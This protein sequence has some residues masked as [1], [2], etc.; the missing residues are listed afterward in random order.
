MCFT[1]KI[2]MTTAVIEFFVGTYLWLTLR[3]KFVVKLLVIFIYLL[4]LYQF[5]EFMLCTSDNPALWGRVGFVSYNFLPAVGL[6]FVIR[7]ARRKFINWVL[8]IPAVTFAVMALVYKDF[9]VASSCNTVFVT[10]KTL[11]FRDVGSIWFT[12][13]YWLYYFGFIFIG[14]W[15]LLLAFIKSKS[16]PQKRLYLYSALATILSLGPAFVFIILLPSYRVQFPSIYCEFALLFA[17]MAL[18]GVRKSKEFEKLD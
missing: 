14:L 17:L 2:S 1:P 12:F 5:S 7:L 3:K 10:V 4:G 13:V 16:L 6:H 8:Y 15:L 18:V 11:F 9:I